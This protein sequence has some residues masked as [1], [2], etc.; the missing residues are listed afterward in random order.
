MILD[1]FYHAMLYAVMA[2]SSVRLSVR[3]KPVLH[4]Y[5][6][7]NRVGFAMQAFYLSYTVIYEE[8][9]VLAKIVL[10]QTLNFKNFDRHGMS[11]VLSTKLVDG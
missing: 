10:P 5:E 7:T 11:I 4:R 3:H 2:C 1:Q 6:R 9:R 8:I